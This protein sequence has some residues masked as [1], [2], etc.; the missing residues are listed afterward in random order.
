MIINLAG[1]ILLGSIV[2]LDRVYMLQLMIS[3]PV[4]IAPLLGLIMGNVHMGLLVGASLELLWLNAPPLG[5]FLP[6]DDTFAAI[7]AIIIASI[8][9]LFL[10][11]HAATG[12]ALVLCLPT[13]IVGRWV[14]NRIRTANN[15]LISDNDKDVKSKIN[16]VMF[17]A[18]S[19]AFLYVFTAISICTA[20]LGIIVYYFTRFIPDPVI[21][22]LSFMPFLSVI[23]GIA[24]LF[25]QVKSR[26]ITGWT[27]SFISGLI[28]VITISWLIR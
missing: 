28:I 4:V 8:A 14:D 21:A 2:W 7:V 22:V 16:R 23:I 17:V 27:V 3:R 5:G 15:S 12:L 18:L 26:S 13:T 10:E 9:H 20:G 6:Y 24:S 11:N 25:A 19:R 1:C